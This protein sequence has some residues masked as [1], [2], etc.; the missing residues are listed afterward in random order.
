[1]SVAWRRLGASEREKTA[2]DLAER[3]AEF[4]RKLGGSVKLLS[5]DGFFVSCILPRKIKIKVNKYEGV[6]RLDIIA[7]SE[8]L[9]VWEPPPRIS[10]FFKS[11]TACTSII[12]QGS[13]GVT[14]VGETSEFK[15]VVTKN[16]D[17]IAI[18]VPE[19]DAFA[20]MD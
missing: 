18:D 4:C 16:Y 8:R 6:N 14:C 10:V 1:L 13:G 11:P 15:V 5:E 9:S 2:R 3:I 7:E 19:Y 20:L 12:T 17:T